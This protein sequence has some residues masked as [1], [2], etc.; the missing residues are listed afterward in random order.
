MGGGSYSSFSYD[1][2]VKNLH[3]S[4]SAFM[5]STTAHRS[6]DLSGNIAEILN[7]R[8]LK[9]GMRESCFA[10]NTD[11]LMSIVVSIDGTGSMMDVPVHLQKEL[12]KLIDVLIEQGITDHP[13]V[14]FMMHDDE[15]A[16]PPDA[17]FQMSQFEIEAPKLLESLNE[18]IIPGNGGGNLS[19]A[20]HLSFYGAANHTRLE[21]FERDGTK[22]FFVLIGDE[23]PYY[24]PN[25]STE[26]T[27]PK[28]AEAVFGD[29]IQAE[30]PF[31]DSVKKVAERYHIIVIRPG[32]T[33]HGND[34]RIT[35]L[36]QDVLKQAGENPQNVLEVEDT[37]AIISTIAMAIGKI[38][39]LEE[40]ELVDVLT[41][42]GA[43]GVHAA[44]NAVKDLATVSG[45]P[46]TV[47]TVNKNIDTGG[48]TAGRER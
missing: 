30:V 17:V 21:G 39:G 36:W 47:S 31:I 19:E 1:N 35:S 37:N 3:D 48:S 12:S 7:P 6:G 45:G 38:S 10:P 29:K 5:R 44:K 16:R 46:M 13:N 15:H 32:A 8:K 27:K 14:L 43:A 33:S 20:Y 22:G 2:S 41:A 25:W 34:R 42:K 24:S 18:M 40:D 11:T 4:G 26:G 23:E 28:V 9:N